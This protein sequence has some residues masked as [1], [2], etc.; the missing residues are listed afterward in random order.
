MLYLLWLDQL[1]MFIDLPIVSRIAK[2]G[3]RLDVLLF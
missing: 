2:G 1:L 3:L